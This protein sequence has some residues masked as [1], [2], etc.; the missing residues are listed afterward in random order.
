M[1]VVIGTE[2]VYSPTGDGHIIAVKY[3]Y[4]DGTYTEKRV[5]IPPKKEK[6]FNAGLK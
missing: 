2:R 4:A 6:G 3:W 5:F 1:K